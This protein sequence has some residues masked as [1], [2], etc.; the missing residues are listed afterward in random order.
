MLHVRVASPAGQTAQIVSLLADSPGVVNLVVLPGAA[1]QPDGDAVQFDLSVAS[2]NPVLRQLRALRPHGAGPIA[3]E[4]V[5]ATIGGGQLDRPHRQAG[6]GRTFQNETAPVW[7]LVESKIAADSVYAPSWYTLLALAGVIG[8][9]GILTNSTILIVG[10]MVVGPEYSAIIAVAM[11]I[12]RHDRSAIW[13]GLRALAVGFAIAIVVTLV[14]SLLIRAIGQVPDAYRDGVRPVSDFI[15]SPDL[16]SVVIAVVAGIIGV[17]SLTE[18]RAGALIGVFISVT[19]IPAAADIG[20]SVAFQSWRAA[21]GST[22]Q[23]LLNVVLLILVGALALRIQRV[24]W[25]D[26]GRAS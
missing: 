9:V 12:E 7:D 19:T 1:R 4:A 24:L 2:A 21:R 16:F 17:V 10:A 15:N 23:L 18:A 6:R 26:R 3:I 20:L 8:A 22:F 14:F 13:R 5:D 11:G 25:R